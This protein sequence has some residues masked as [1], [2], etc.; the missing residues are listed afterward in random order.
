VPIISTVVPGLVIEE[1]FESNSPTSDA[2][3]LQ[4]RRSARI[5]SRGSS[6]SM[7]VPSNPAP[8]PTRSKPKPKGSNKHQAPRRQSRRL[9]G[10]DA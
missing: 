8:R 4:K 7:E 5:A 1:D 2:E 6:S 9:A 10:K 3:P